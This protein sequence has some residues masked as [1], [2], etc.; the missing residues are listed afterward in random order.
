M[1]LIMRIPQVEGRGSA[2]GRTIAIVLFLVPIILVRARL[3]VIEI[4]RILIQGRLRIVGSA[5]LMARQVP[6][7]FP[8]SGP[9]Q[10][11]FSSYDDRNTFSGCC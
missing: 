4:I 5:M 1:I 2:P 3:S 10:A 9:V 8:V 7:R 6:C 11:Y